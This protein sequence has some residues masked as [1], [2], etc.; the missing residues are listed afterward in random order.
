M[1]FSSTFL[2]CADFPFEIFLHDLPILR[3]AQLK[4]ACTIMC[5]HNFIDSPGFSDKEF[6]LG[7]ID[8]ASH[9]LITS[10]LTENQ[11]ET[12]VTILS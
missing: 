8:M 9:S 11:E 7:R 4:C 3:I 12:C 10:L 6:S 5:N 2:K 1:I